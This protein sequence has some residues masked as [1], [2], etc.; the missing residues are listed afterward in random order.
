MAHNERT[1]GAGGRTGALEIVA[2]QADVSRA[3]A[4]APFLQARRIAERS[5]FSP[6]VA[7]GVSEDWGGHV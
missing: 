3:T 4:L 5:R 2:S 7:Y 6:A 1:P